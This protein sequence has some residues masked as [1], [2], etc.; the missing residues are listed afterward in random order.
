MRATYQGGIREEWA[1]RVTPRP[2]SDPRTA[3]ST[4]GTGRTICGGRGTRAR[5]KR[6]PAPRLSAVAADGPQPGPDAP[7]D[8]DRDGRGRGRRPCIP[9]A[10][11]RAPLP[12]WTASAPAARPGGRSRFPDA[13]GPLAYFS[14]EFALHQSLP[15]YAGGLGVL[16]GDHCKEASDLGVPLD[17][18][19]VHVSAGLLPSERLA[20]G[21][22]D[23]GLRA[24]ELGRRAGRSG[25]DA[26]RQA[27]RHRGAAR[28]PLGARG[29]VAGPPRPRDAVPARHGSRGEHAVGSRAVGSPLRRRSRDPDSAGDHPRHRRRPRA[30]G[31]RP[32]TRGLAPERGPRGVRRPAAH[33][34]P[35]RARRDASTRR[36]RKSGGR[37]SSR[38]TRRCPPATT[39]SRSIWWKRIWPAPGARSARRAMRSSRSATTTTAAD[40]SS[41]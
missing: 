27:V 40:R 9:A 25:A 5:A 28:Q 21:L 30:E 8:L 6:L 22:A 4:S 24:S 17:R 32:G 31:A 16:A 39:P 1:T 7:A 10:V 26:R 15:I 2:G 41:T 3:S 33:P 34:R 29:G 36:S 37:R 23:G 20:R 11:R 12:R 18:R 19:R 38:P 14:A 35:D 13:A